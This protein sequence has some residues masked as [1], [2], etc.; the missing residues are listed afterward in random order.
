MRGKDRRP[1]R[2]Y[3]PR[4]REDGM[5]IHDEAYT[6]T[7]LDFQ[8][9]CAARPMPFRRCMIDALR[10]YMADAPPVPPPL[11]LGSLGSGSE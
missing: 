5:A 8:E 3:K 11:T 4:P 10:R 9:W 7:L 2:M 6:Q 1:G